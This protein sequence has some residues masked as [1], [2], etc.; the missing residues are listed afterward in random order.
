VQHYHN[1]GVI[2]VSRKASTPKNTV[3]AANRKALI[4]AIDD[5]PETKNDLPSCVADSKAITALLQSEP[6]GFREIVTYTNEQ[7]T[8]A[9]VKA[10]LNWLL[11]NPTALTASDRL[12]LYFSGH[13]YRTEKDGLL[14]ECLC[15]H[16]GFLFDT[17][18]TQLTQSLPS[19]ILSIILDCCHA[20]GMEKNFNEFLM[21]AE[22]P[23]EPVETARIKTWLPSAEDIGKTFSP[24][25]A[26]L[27]VKSFGGPVRPNAIAPDFALKSAEPQANALL[28]TA[29]RADQTASASS[30]QTQGKSAFTYSLLEALKQFGANSVVSNRQLFDQVSAIL[31]ALRFKQIPVL[32]EPG[33]A[34]GLSNTSFITLQPTSTTTAPSKSFDPTA[35]TDST[36]TQSKGEQSMSTT[37]TPTLALDRPLTEADA[38]FCAAVMD[39]CLKA[40]PAMYQ[41]TSGK[42]FSNGQEPVADGKF[43]GAIIGA[44]ATAIPGIISAISGK[45]FQQASTAPIA[46]DKFWTQVISGAIGAIPGII[47]LVTGKD[48]QEGVGVPITPAVETPTPVAPLPMPIPAPASPS[49]PVVSNPGPLP[50]VPSNGNGAVPPEVDEKFWG[51]LL[52]GVIPAIAGAVSR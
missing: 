39:A 26:A 33:N 31:A 9:Q 24:E 35:S 11:G 44:A 6:Y 32:H 1:R 18:L 41:A 34:L 49:V 16:D 4:V 5:Y 3:P 47:D 22:N 29:C 8:L 37:Q 21:S 23:G 46:E 30:S 27:P 45:D 19:G 13:G 14:R 52:A 17:E 15:L 2:M 12:V 25:Q 40:A 51:A 48:F 7:A 10:G 28:I 43:W 20:G 42:D 36:T 50:Q 38:K